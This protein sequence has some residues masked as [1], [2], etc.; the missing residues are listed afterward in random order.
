MAN[1]LQQNQYDSNQYSRI[2]FY[3]NCYYQSYCQR[4]RCLLWQFL[5]YYNIQS[6]SLKNYTQKYQNQIV[7]VIQK[8]DPDQPKSDRFIAAIYSPEQSKFQGLL[9]LST[10]VLSVFNFSQLK[11]DYKVELFLL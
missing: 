5:Q 3:R 7:M 4:S 2:Y 1:L 11:V 10:S 8:F 6:Y 9:D